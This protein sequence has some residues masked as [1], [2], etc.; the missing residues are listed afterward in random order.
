MFFLVLFASAV[1]V[2]AQSVMAMPGTVPGTTDVIFIAANPG[3]GTSVY[4]DFEEIIWNPPP[5]NPQIGLFS[6]VPFTFDNRLLGPQP[7]LVMQGVVGT[8]VTLPS[9]RSWRFEIYQTVPGG[10][11]YT[12]PNPPTPGPKGMNLIAPFGT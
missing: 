8:R 12:F 6:R 7:G 4:V 9:G 5:L 2:E 1:R 10:L 3:P 11:L